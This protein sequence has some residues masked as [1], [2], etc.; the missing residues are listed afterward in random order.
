MNLNQYYTQQR[1]SDLLV[2]R[3]LSESPQIAVDL[4][5]GDGELLFAARRRWHEIN[6]VGVD[7]DPKNVLKANQAKIISAI[8]F[9]GFNPS[10]P[11]I[12]Q[13]RFG[14]INLLISNPPYFP[15][16]NDKSTREIIKKAGMSQCIPATCKKIPAELIFLAQN[17]AMLSKSGEIGI[18][19]P[20][21]VISGE[22][23]KGVREFL[24]S[25]LKVNNLI[26]LPS[27]SFI[28]TDAQT[29]ILTLSKEKSRRD[30]I[31]LSHATH[32]STL[33]VKINDAINRA[34]FLYYS[35]FLNNVCEQNL[36]EESFSILRGSLSH[37]FL[38]KHVAEYL[39]TTDLPSKP[40]SLNLTNSPISN[41][42]NAIKGDILLARVG[43]R[44][45]GKVAIVE[46]GS[47]PVSDCV[48][49]VRAKSDEERNQIWRILSAPKSRMT[50][51]NR[52]LGVGAKYI[53][54]SIVKEYLIDVRSAT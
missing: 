11:E 20:A 12:I 51:Y 53:T 28:N 14:N 19:L 8:E 47:I 45:L 35:S 52:S 54:H 46:S 6:L 9:D 31:T 5:F 23:W 4:G 27:D 41:A 32:S 16:D 7:I 39:H 44:C 17:I 15:K 37:T 3:L 50:L 29:F 48:I 2:G 38:R 43:R 40:S 24:F 1:Y 10:L 25:E 26:Q 33:N 36:N 49:I 13:E 30:F 21:G 22:R 42:N 18:I 34:D